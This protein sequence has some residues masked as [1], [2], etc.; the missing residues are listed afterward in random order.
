ML[1]DCSRYKNRFFMRLL[2]L[3][4]LSSFSVSSVAQP[5]HDYLPLEL[6]EGWV[7]MD[8]AGVE[9]TI[10][11]AFQ[12]EIAG[13]PCYRME[14]SAPD[15]MDGAPYQTEFWCLSEEGVYLVARSMFGRRT[16]F[17]DPPLLIYRPLSDGIHW[18]NITGEGVLTDTST[19]V[20]EGWENVT[21]PAGTFDA[22]L[23]AAYPSVGL[24]T[25]IERWYALGV[26][27]VRERSHVGEGENQQV[28]ADKKLVRR[29]GQ[30]PK[31][32]AA[33]G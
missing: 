2:L 9:V 29:I 1:H 21:T 30:A 7:Y 18:E 33:D 11:A 32:A 14:R 4:I 13:L 12:Q 19:F 25:K 6:N 3:L 5:Q 27:I 23:I 26:G 8:E 10:R 20:V 16:I 28:S 15:I 17:P 24:V 22:V 31:E